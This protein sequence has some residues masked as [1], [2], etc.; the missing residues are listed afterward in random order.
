ME[1]ISIHERKWIDIE[2]SQKQMPK[3]AQSYRVSNGM[4]SSLRHGT[5]PREED[6]VIEFWRLKEDFK[7][8][9]P[10]S[11]DWLIGMRMDHL[12]QGEEDK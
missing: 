12:Q 7:Q 3:D 11:V 2:P 10:H 8:G 5:I 6:G 1:Q 4:I 9:F